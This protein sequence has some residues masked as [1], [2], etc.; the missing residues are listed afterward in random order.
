MVDVD[1]VRRT[2]VVH[3]PATYTGKVAV[4]LLVDMHGLFGN[5]QGQLTG[6]GSAQVADREGFIAAYPNG[7]DNAWNI[8]PCCTHDRDVDDVGFM[9]ALVEKLAN[10]AC[11]DPSRVYA[12]GVSMGGG[13]SHYLACEAAEVFAAVA[14]AAFDLLEEN[15]CAP[16]RPIAVL[17]ARG[18]ADA[19]VPYAGGPSTPPNGVPT[20]IH[21]RGAKGTF[22]EWARINACNGNP[23]QAYDGCESY[24]QC[25]GDVE[26]TLCTEQGGRHTY[27]DPERAWEMLSKYRLP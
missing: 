19:I 18:T 7:I 16:S 21:F 17:L 13:M 1:G 4:P 2:Y 15:T 12:T 14:P 9:R 11:I 10:D 8:G 26:V 27:G 20:T 24:T 25:A 6:S 5:A 23:S 3:V 22:E